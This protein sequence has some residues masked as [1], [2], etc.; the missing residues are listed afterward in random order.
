MAA[1]REAV[2]SIEPTAEPDGKELA[3]HSDAHPGAMLGVAYARHF[4]AATAV[5]QCVEQ[6]GAKRP[7][8]L[9]VFCGGKHEPG[10]VR[11]ALRAVY[12]D[13][14]VVGGSAAGAISGTGF[15][16]SGLELAILAFF[17]PAI[18]PRLVLE[19]GLL[20][21]EIEAG[22]ALG[23]QVA[24]VAE[25]NALV[26]LFF[27][28]VATS[29]PLR[30]HYAS[31]IVEGF[32]AGLDGK[33]V[34][35][36]GGGLLT[37]MNLSDG[38]VFTGRA[39]RKHAAVAL[40]FPPAV[41]AGT[42]V[43]HGCRPVSTFMRITR[44]EGAEVF[45]LDGE[46]A[47]S[48]IERMLNVSLGGPEGHDLT[49]L[50]TLGEK[51]GDP[52]APYDENAYVNRLIVTSDRGRGSVTLFEPDFH[53]GTMVQIMSRDNSLMLQSVQDGVAAANRAQ[54]A[55][56]RLLN[57]YIDCA[58]RGSA[59]SGAST[60]EAEMVLRGLDLSV[61]LIGFYSGV[62]IAPF[63]GYSRPLDWTGVLTT[64]RWAP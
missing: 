26:L 10:Q 29:A 63:N 56:T 18:T 42:V 25:P 36:I 59:R 3:A 47:L 1:S 58:G 17:D 20:E 14:D 19:T 12:G 41:Q 33:R 28:S 32:Q 53:V 61:P 2:V 48:V 21:G 16:Y 43:L 31:S 62:E 13:V 44:I 46:P 51:Q 24:T 22:R 35:L 15:G 6:L 23:A 7:T 4:E 30:L 40:V 57:L 27:D 5:A 38:W 8:L 9:L 45:E 64:L 11:D 49:L 39:V 52:F 55:G 60:E 37:D 34:E 54:A 50:A